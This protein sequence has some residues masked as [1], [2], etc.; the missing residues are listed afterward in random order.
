MVDYLAVVEFNTEDGRLF[1]VSSKKRYE[2]VDFEEVEVIYNPKDPSDLILD[3]YYTDGSR[4]ANGILLASSALALGA[5]YG[6]CSVM[7]ILLTE[8]M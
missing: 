8:F 6:L 5:A 4:G 3:D 2:E 7:Y 1:R